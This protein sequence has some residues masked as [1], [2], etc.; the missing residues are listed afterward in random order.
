MSLTSLIR[1][2]KMLVLL[3]E[4]V[5]SPGPPPKLSPLVP[6][7]SEHPRRVGTAFDY[8]LRFHLQSVNPTAQG[9][10]WVAE[11][12]VYSLSYV[13]VGSGID[14]L[15]YFDNP[16]LQ[17]RTALAHK[18]LEEARF[19]HR[20]YLSTG[21]LRDDLLVS[22][23]RLA[24]LDVIYRAGQDYVS[25]DVLESANSN[26]VADLRALYEVAQ[27]INWRAEKACFL[28][29]TFNTASPLVGG[30]DADVILDS[31]LIDIKTTKDIK[32]DKHY[33]YQLVGYYLLLLLDGVTN[34]G[35]GGGADEA[36]LYAET[37]SEITELSIYF[38]R[39][40]HLHKIRADEL[41]P[42]NQLKTFALRFVEI[43]CP[44]RKK[45]QQHWRNFRGALA[46]AARDI[47]S[48]KKTLLKKKPKQQGTKKKKRAS[49]LARIKKKRK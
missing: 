6:V 16:A 4:M 32:L 37:I 31:Q 35:K 17:E 23:L 13:R 30:A 26:D 10:R 8:L 7:R 24:E 38:S 34:P 1:E 3:R 49:V 45:R 43:A 44:A 19:F 27:K 21:L 25:W 42:P 29:P 14:P 11:S 39:F 12:G 20:D 28:N 9:D 15:E 41:M 5:R 40:G 36:I 47:P 18:C 33:L 2:P 48:M 22:T 46:L